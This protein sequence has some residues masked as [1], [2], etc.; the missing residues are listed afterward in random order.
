MKQDKAIF[1]HS[2]VLNLFIVYVLDTCL[3]DLSTEL[4]RVGC[5]F[6]AVKSTKNVHLNKCAYSDYGSGFD[7]H[8][9]CFLSNCN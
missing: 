4:T 2:N 3:K 8:S 6:A 9:Q 5:F 1:T 7:T